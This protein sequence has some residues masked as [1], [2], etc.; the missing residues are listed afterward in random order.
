MCVLHERG[1]IILIIFIKKSKFQFQLN[2]ILLKLIDICKYTYTYRR[3]YILYGAAENFQIIRQAIK[4]RFCF[5]RL[6]Y[7]EFIRRA[8]KGLITKTKP[9]RYGMQK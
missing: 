3:S 5:V 4:D 7:I 6:Q 8:T 1:T 2:A 9:N